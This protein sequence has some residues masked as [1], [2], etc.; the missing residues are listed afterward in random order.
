MA[1]DSAVDEANIDLELLR[2]SARE[3]LSERGD[4]DSVEDLARMDWTGLLV[5]ES[6]GGAGW[7]PVETVVIAEELGRAGDR[8]GW[9]GTTLAAAALASAP[10]EV[11]DRWLPSV[12]DGNLRAGLALSGGTV[13]V[14]NADTLRLL[15]TVGGNGVRIFELTEATFRCRDEELLEVSRPAWRVEL[16]GM[17]GLLIGESPRSDQLL[18]VARV[19]IS[20]DSLG[21]LSA[22]FERLVAY[23]KDR[24]AFGAPIASFQAVQHRLVELL[25]LEAKARAVTMKAARALATTEVSSSAVELSAAAHAFVTAQATRAIDEC[26]Q[27]SGG[28]GFTWEYPL[29]H[30]MRR[31][32]TNSHLLGSARMSRTAYA[33]QV[34]W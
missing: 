8:S 26:M 28:I 6:L 32:F 34:G 12:L 31:A 3:F 16:A 1:P 22:T 14:T 5:D 29:H 7:L 30:E 4:K 19:L 24:I 10:A 27:L 18:A 15:I 25:V 20:A 13:R 17:E 21:A 23:L 9:F 2:S 11:R 33:K